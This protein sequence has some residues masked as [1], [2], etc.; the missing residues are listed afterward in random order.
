MNQ[1]HPVIAQA[2]RPF[3]PSYPLKPTEEPADFEA[4]DAAMLRDKQ[5]DGYGL[6]NQA[7]ALRLQLADHLPC[8]L[9]K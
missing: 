5:N 1:L 6:R 8:L 7:Q 4:I 9:E 3:I 2:L